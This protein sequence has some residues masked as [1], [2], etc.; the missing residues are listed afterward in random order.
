MSEY[1]RLTAKG[2]KVYRWAPP[3]GNGAGWWRGYRDGSWGFAMGHLAAKMTDEEKAAQ[4]AQ[5][6]RLRGWG[7]RSSS[8]VYR[9]DYDNQDMGGNFHSRPVA[10]HL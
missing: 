2:V 3:E 7:G 10:V 1:D 5:I 8:G 9:R 6:S 4:Q